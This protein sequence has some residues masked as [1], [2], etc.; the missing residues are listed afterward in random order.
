MYIYGND[1]FNS[2]WN[3]THFRKKKLSI[4]AKRY[5]L[6][7]V[8]FFSENSAFYAVMWKIWYSQTCHRW[9]YGARKF[10]AW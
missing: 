7:S 3:E 6:C 4:R 1:K 5:I 8:T 10:H 9:K 2:S